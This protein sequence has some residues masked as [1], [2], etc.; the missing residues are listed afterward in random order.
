MPFPPTTQEPD[1]QTNAMAG[2]ELVR[3]VMF[4]RTAIQ[5]RVEALGAEITR[6]YGDK[7]LVLVTA[8]QGAM[9]FFA[10]LARQIKL[11]LICDVVWVTSYE[12]GTTSSGTIRTLLAPGEEW[13]DRDVLFIEDIV[14]TGRTGAH[15][16]QLARERRARTARLCTLLD[17]PSR[18]VLDFYAD[19][20]G[21]G[22]S[23]RFVIGYGLDWNGRGRNLDFIGAID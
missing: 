23:N 16:M 1:E 6:D 15:L 12:G 17:K 22:L 7:D 4:S 13:R 18:R 14:D 11:S 19:Y 9:F 10:D 21:F 2:R 8:M 20:V 5:R 3:E